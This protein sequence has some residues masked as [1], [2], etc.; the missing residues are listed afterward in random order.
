MSAVE[1]DELEKLRRTIAKKRGVSLVSPSEF[2]AG[3]PSTVAEHIDQLSRRVLCTNL[4]RWMS[5]I[6][7]LSDAHG[8]Y[9]YKLSDEQ[10]KFPYKY[11]L[12][13]AG[14]GFQ[15]R[16]SK[17]EYISAISEEV[18]GEM[19]SNELLQTYFTTVGCSNIF[20]G[21]I[22]IESLNHAKTAF[23]KLI[24]HD[25]CDFT[26]KLIGNMTLHQIGFLS[27]WK[28][29]LFRNVV[30]CEAEPEL[31]LPLVFNTFGLN[32]PKFP[33]PVLDVWLALHTK[34]EDDAAKCLV[35]YVMIPTLQE[36]LWSEELVGCRHIVN[37]LEELKSQKHEFKKL[38]N[39]L[40]FKQMEKGSGW[41]VESLWPLLWDCDTLSRY[42]SLDMQIL[43]GK[44]P[45][46]DAEIIQS[47]LSTWGESWRV[48]ADFCNPEVCQ[49]DDATDDE[50]ID[51]FRQMWRKI[52]SIGKPPNVEPDFSDELEQIDNLEKREV[53]RE[54]KLWVYRRV[55]AELNL[56]ESIRD[57]MREKLNRVRIIRLHVAEQDRALARVAIKFGQKYRI[58]G[59]NMD[60]VL[61]ALAKFELQ[62]IENCNARSTWTCLEDLCMED[63]ALAKCTET[64][65][66][67]RQAY[68]LKMASAVLYGRT[69]SSLQG[70]FVPI[71][72]DCP[73]FD[74]GE[75][76]DR[77]QKVYEKVDVPAV[78]SILDW[79]GFLWRS[80]LQ[81]SDTSGNANA[82]A[83][84]IQLPL[85]VRLMDTLF[86]ASERSP[87][88][89]VSLMKK[90][91]L[92]PKVVVN[93]ALSMKVLAS[94]RL[95]PQEQREAVTTL[96]SWIPFK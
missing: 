14:V 59:N 61:E 86:V 58:P 71:P 67:G 46:T 17:G 74:E 56:C 57:K 68:P 94:K 18:F 11:A 92:K 60:V 82:G 72:A 44:L 78:G 42:T 93:C 10:M 81:R 36:W 89:F 34:S 69:I 96:M 30:V 95:V 80:I 31:P 9:P 8:N 48:S 2:T 6:S 23:C 33:Q 49:P 75:V 88:F 1:S 70:H 39:E 27:H 40:V 45:K 91:N 7:E 38:A 54:F 53:S 50:K 21:Y 85:I 5:N 84:L 66:L 15:N 87:S 64:Q 32:C 19:K 13:S 63:E 76:N 20:A 65:S 83:N 16:L 22:H 35:D 62:L 73:Q 52:C 41:Q 43:N 37:V 51:E 28:E 90:L 77:L 26:H 79:I 24:E 55:A 29:L 12:Q 3:Y 4:L 47:A 25:N